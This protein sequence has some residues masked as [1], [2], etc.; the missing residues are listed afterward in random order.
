MALG[1]HSGDFPEAYDSPIDDHEEP[2]TPAGGA[3][4]LGSFRKHVADERAATR[5]RNRERAEAKPPAVRYR[6]GGDVI[7]SLECHGRGEAGSH[8]FRADLPPELEDRRDGDWAFFVEGEFGI[9]EGNEVLLGAPA[10]PSVPG[11]FPIEA[12]VAKIRG[13]D[14]WLA[15]D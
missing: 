11:A 10:D 5:A 7:P 9:H 4:L 1:L 6:E 2:H 14:I 13:L 15:F 8:R 3:A 12:D